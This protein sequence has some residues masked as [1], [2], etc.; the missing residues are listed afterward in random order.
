MLNHRSP[1]AA[2]PFS[3]QVALVTG[4]S[5]GIGSAMAAA[6]AVRGATICLVGRNMERLRC[7]A[8]AAGGIED[9]TRCYMADL[10]R[11]EDI[12]ELTLRIQNDFGDIDMLIHSA[13]VISLGRVESA[14]VR[15]FDLQYSTNVRAAYYLTQSMLPLLRVR[16]G[17][18]V[19]FNSS[20]GLAANVNAAQY[21]ATKHALKAIADSL[22]DE[23]NA[24]GLRVLSVFLGR[25]ATPMQAAIHAQEGQRYQPERLLQPEDVASVVLNALSLPRTAEVT[26]IRIR[27][28][29]KPC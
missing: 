18:I 6:L 5:S 4:G 13:G 12:D 27:P 26:D 22:R 29:K 25:T 28:L 10:T 23:I 15:D 14:A 8:K 19:F 11:D 3:G 1:N 20:A 24:E 7:A 2:D 21:S 16:R 9:R 17:Q